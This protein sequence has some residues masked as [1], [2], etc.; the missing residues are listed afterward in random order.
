MPCPPV[1]RRSVL[2]LACALH[3]FA[4]DP[5]TVTPA[6]AAGVLARRVWR[7][8]RGARRLFRD[9][10]L[11]IVLFALL[12][13]SW[14]AQTWFGWRE[15]AAEQ[16]SHGEAAELFGPGGSVWSWGRT[17]FENWESEFRQLFATVTLTPFLLFR[18]SPE[19]NDGDEEMRATLAHLE[20]R[21][22]DLSRATVRE[23]A[24]R[25]LPARRTGSG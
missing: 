24:G 9:S 15:F 23:T 6:S 7:K 2:P 22:N 25:R 5:R 4:P 21:L 20:R 13:A 12:L 19:S 3:R 18:A 8:E 1:L 17:T 16:A 14:L 11:G 10:G